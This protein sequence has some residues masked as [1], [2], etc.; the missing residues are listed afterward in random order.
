V[1]EPTWGG[2]LK[3]YRIA[4]FAATGLAMTLGAQWTL[5]AQQKISN[6]DRDRAQEIL[7]DVHEDVKKHYYDEKFHGVD[8]DARYKAYKVKIDQAQNLG[9][10]FRD[11]AAYLSALQDSHTYMVPPERSSRF[12]YGVRS[13]M[14][15]DAAYVTE[16]RPGSDAAAKLH[17][18]DQILGINGYAVN[19][20][21][22]QDL[23]YFL[24]S[25]APQTALIM[26]LRDPSG[27]MRKETVQTKFQPRKKII[28]EVGA[29]SDASL[30]DYTR[31]EEL[32]EHLLRERWY[33]MGDVMIWKM[34]EFDMDDG[35]INDM[36][37]RARKH[38]TLIMDLRGNPGGSV[39]VLEKVVGYVMDHNVTIATRVSRR[40]EKPLIAK[41]RGDDAFKGKLIV[42]ID[43]R[44][45]S[46]AEL[47]AQTV[48]LEHRGTIV[49]DQSAGAVMESKFYPHQFEIPQAEGSILIPYGT[50]VT[51]ANLIMADGKSL[52]GVGVT[53]DVIVLPTG[54]DLAAGR[55]PA[56][57]KAAELAGVK[58]DPAAAG[59]LFPFEWAPLSEE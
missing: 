17:I 58:L 25:L 28:D 26:D 31:Q 47:F 1:R 12:D 7:Q 3:I 35:T 11:I 38:K 36:F 24:Y 15:G 52:E 27:I 39:D 54:A 48:Q 29:E 56:L 18:G 22:F 4:I 16:V 43:S 49:G 45:A 6:A 42:L 5:R 14:I 40:P 30:W 23:S 32:A 9:E 53:P 59:K 10:A 51:D 33:E 55:D 34:P 21:D 19:R 57:A 50:S 8:L 20:K 2:A 41:S 44:S 37:G 13:E 46:A